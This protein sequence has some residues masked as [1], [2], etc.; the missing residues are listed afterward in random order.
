VRQFT[1]RCIAACYTCGMRKHWT[2]W[3]WPA[4]LSC[5]DSLVVFAA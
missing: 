3:S 2:F 4:Q 1:E 5:T